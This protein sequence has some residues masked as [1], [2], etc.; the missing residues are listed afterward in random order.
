M[1]KIFSLLMMF[2]IL[3]NFAFAQSG[4]IASVQPKLN[5]QAVVRDANNQLLFNDEMSVQ[6]NIN[7]GSDVYSETHASV[8]TNENGLMNVII[9]GDDATDVT[10]SLEKV[11]WAGATIEAVI[12]YTT[13]PV[14]VT[15]SD[16]TVTTSAGEEATI[17]VSA[18]VTAVPYAL[19]AGP[20]KL[21]TEMIVDYVY[22]AEY[23]TETDKYDALAIADAILYNP[24]NLKNNLKDTV[25]R[26][27]KA[28]KDIAKDIFKS[29]LEQTTAEDV[30]D[31]YDHLMANTAA[32]NKLRDLSK[33]FIK[34]HKEE[35]AEVAQYYA[36]HATID[37]ITPIYNALRANSD[38]M[39]TVKKLVKSHLAE[40]LSDHHYVSDSACTGIEICAIA[41]AGKPCPATDFIGTTTVV[42]DKLQTTITNPNDLSL[43][44]TYEV[45]Y[46]LLGES[47][48]ETYVGHKVSQNLVEM[49]DVLTAIPSDPNVTNFHGTVTIH[50]Y[51]CDASYDRTA[52]FNF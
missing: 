5:F 16:G 22:N 51:G 46:N 20:S 19:Q 50:S 37:D 17:T 18:P 8:M 9:G 38:I 40:Y 29:Y 31:V 28:H 26:Y 41:N 3:G 34:T 42:G 47:R 24:N 6:I 14:T 36:E 33:E 23:G 32:V 43:Q 30:Q 21:T 52:T 12:T 27:L 2:L 13:D 4:T 44:I 10:G 7:Y 45:S 11:N 35:A 15:N 49:E 1:K 25:I 48:N 39:N